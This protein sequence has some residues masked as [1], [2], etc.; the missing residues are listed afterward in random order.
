[1]SLDSCSILCCTSLSNKH[2]C[3]ARDPKLFPDRD[4]YDQILDT[5]NGTCI[6]STLVEQGMPAV[7]INIRTDK[8]YCSKNVFWNYNFSSPSCICIHIV[9]HSSKQLRKLSSSFQRQCCLLCA[10]TLDPLLWEC[11]HKLKKGR[12]VV[13]DF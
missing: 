5:R 3:T 6:C 13:N 12:L 9:F 8:F 11:R 7:P 10:K 4:K 1:M 2:I